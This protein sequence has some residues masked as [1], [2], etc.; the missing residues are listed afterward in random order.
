VTFHQQSMVAGSGSAND[1]VDDSLAK[2][3]QKYLEYGRGNGAD[4]VSDD[5]AE[6]ILLAHSIGPPFVFVNPPKEATICVRLN[7]LWPG[8]FWL[9]PYLLFAALNASKGIL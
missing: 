3:V 7:L 4:L 2:L 6:N 5:D 8:S 9:S 1:D